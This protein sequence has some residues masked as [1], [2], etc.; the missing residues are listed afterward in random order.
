MAGLVVCKRDALATTGFVLTV[1]G[2]LD[3]SRHGDA[4]SRGLRKR[5]FEQCGRV[6][7]DVQITRNLRRDVSSN[8]FSMLA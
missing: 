6:E 2:Q 7:C 4:G 8:M 5:D 1:S 3:T